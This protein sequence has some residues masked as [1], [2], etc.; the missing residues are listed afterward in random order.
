M[1]KSVLKALNFL[2]F[3]SFRIRVYFFLP[4]TRDTCMKFRYQL[5]SIL[6]IPKL[7]VLLLV[8][9]SLII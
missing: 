4:T 7:F 5:I 9:S 8:M 2:S 6:Q 1:K 3:C